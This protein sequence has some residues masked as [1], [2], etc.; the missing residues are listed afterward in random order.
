MERE[1]LCFCGNV[2]IR[3]CMTCDDFVCASHDTTGCRYV[4]G[5]P[6]TPEEVAVA[7]SE[8]DESEVVL[9]DRL[10]TPPTGPTRPNT[11]SYC[12]NFV[13][14]G[15]GRC[16]ECKSE[17]CQSCEIAGCHDEFH[18]EDAVPYWLRE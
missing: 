11:C 4:V 12:M 14:L 6:G 3:K 7:E 2:A 10:K 5:V 15:G 17:W 13:A 9:P 1:P 18:D 16:E 8:F